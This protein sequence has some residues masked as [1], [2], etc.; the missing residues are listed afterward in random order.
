MHLFVSGRSRRMGM[1]VVPLV[2]SCFLFAECAPRTGVAP[3]SSASE[4]ITRVEITRS[5]A[6]NA[7]DA[8]RIL[9]PN[10]LR[11]RGRVTIRGTDIREPL[12][13]LDNQRMGGIN[14]LRDIPVTEIFEIRYHTA[15]QAQIKWGNGHPQ[16]VIQ[17]LTARTSTP[18]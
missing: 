4:A 18:E 10:M 5:Q 13:Y 11:E 15:A 12:V 1:R 3:A 14:F 16:G 8:I 2:A 9:R 7:Y 17:V 6:F